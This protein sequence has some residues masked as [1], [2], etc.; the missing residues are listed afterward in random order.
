MEQ[1]TKIPDEN[2]QSVLTSEARIEHIRRLEREAQAKDWSEDPRQWPAP[3]G[4][5][6]MDLCDEQFAFEN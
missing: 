3:I 1:Y 5:R 2:G 6:Y 4:N